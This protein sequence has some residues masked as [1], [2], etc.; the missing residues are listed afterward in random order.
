MKAWFLV[1][2]IFLSGGYLFADISLNA[3]Q[4]SREE[5]QRRFNELEGQIRLSEQVRR[6]QQEL[7]EGP[8]PE[9]IIPIK[10]L[11]PSYWR[12]GIAQLKRVLQDPPKLPASG[13][14]AGAAAGAAT[15]A[16]A[17]V[18]LYWLWKLARRARLR[19]VDKVHFSVTSPPSVMRG[20]PFVVDIWAHLE[21]QREEVI[22]RARESL[23]FFREPKIQTKGPVRVAR[24]TTLL[25]RL[26][27]DDLI[28]NDAEDAEDVILWEGE[29][30][31]ATFAVKVPV[32]AEDGTRVGLATIHMY[33]LEI[34][35][36]Y[37][38]IQVGQFTGEVD[39][40]PIREYVH[41][42]AFASYASLDRKDVLGRIQMAKKIKPDLD[43]FVDVLS[44]RSGQLW[45]QKLYKFIQ[46]SDTFYLFWSDHA[47]KSE[48]VEKEWRYALQTKGITFINPVIL[49][50][51]EEV[52]PPQE[53]KMLHFNDPEHANMCGKKR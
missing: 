19:R 49:C 33:G 22:E 36:I 37:F 20:T 21:E 3:G 43:I 4:E 51:L 6:L 40:L 8:D 42:R 2:L 12:E 10:P 11:K 14:V 47:R 38:D 35:K 15:A 13:L 17:G 34:A 46:E 27:I 39:N 53:L 44:L 30:G 52:P 5:L 26:K 1:L 45:E 24:G 9:I 48:W 32:D 16:G 50:S 31:N 7:L 18:G 25:V 29:I 41:R 28:I 23:V